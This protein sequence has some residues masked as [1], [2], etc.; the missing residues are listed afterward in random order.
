MP[1]QQTPKLFWNGIGQW[2]S[3]SDWFPIEVNVPDVINNIVNGVSGV[4]GSNGQRIPIINRITS[5]VQPRPLPFYATFPMPVDQIPY[6]V[7][8]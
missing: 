5:G 7:Y 3:G 6:S 2:I 1:Y 8:P 4:V